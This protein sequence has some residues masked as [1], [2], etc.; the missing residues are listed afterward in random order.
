MTSWLNNELDLNR[1]LF[2]G[3]NVQNNVFFLSYEITWIVHLL[4]HYSTYVSFDVL[5]KMQSRVIWILKFGT[6]VKINVYFQSRKKKEKKR[7]SK[8]R[9]KGS[10]NLK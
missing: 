3:F 6:Y 4:T 2:I 9:E 1:F 5:N 7:K 8:R 10:E